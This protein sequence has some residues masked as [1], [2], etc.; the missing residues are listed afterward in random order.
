[1]VDAMFTFAN[2]PTLPSSTPL[3]FYQAIEADYAGIPLGGDW[4]GTHFSDYNG[5][6]YWRVQSMIR[7]E[8]GV[9]LNDSYGAREK[10]TD[11][12]Y[13]FIPVNYEFLSDNATNAP[14]M[15]HDYRKL[16]RENCL[17]NFKTLIKAISKTPAMLIYLSGQ[18][19]TKTVP[20]ENFARE[21]FE[22]FT[23]GKENDEANQ[24]YTED[25]IKAA[26]KIFSGWRI[27]NFLAP[28]PWQINFDYNYHNRDNKQ[29]SSFF[30]NQI[31]N[32]QVNAAGA[33]EYDIFFDM[34]F[35]KQGLTIAKYICR[36]MYRYFVY[37]EIDANTE[38]NIIT[39]L[40]NKLVANNW[41]TKSVFEELF[42]SEHF[43]DS[44]N[45][46]V[47]IKSPI[48]FHLGLMRSLNMSNVSPAGFTDYVNQ[49]NIWGD[50]QWNTDK[51]LEQGIGLVPNVS[52]WKAYYQSPS[53]YQNWINS[54]TI[55][56]RESMI[57]SYINGYTRHTL[58]L[59]I[60]TIAYVQ[61]FGSTIV[62]E[63]DLLIE[64]VVKHLLPLDIDAVYKTDTLKKA[65]LLK[66]Q[67]DPYY[68]KTAWNNYLADSTNTTKKNTVINL[69]K[70]MITGVLKLAE[71]Q[72]M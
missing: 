54:N 6:N 72:L 58:K 5:N 47:M 2:T 25:D 59:Q 49:Y 69:L 44:I 14:T 51:N 34:L 45:R 70:S 11:F 4:T 18:F 32:N 65:N 9:R 52:G 71:Y 68:W 16:L 8:W 50:F 13:H 48:D 56:Q 24:K 3:N 27:N 46:G 39:P 61:Q 22:L 26:S 53:Y 41:E 64:A 55:Q 35:A 29:F 62:P 7:W 31:I 43:F 63:A 36:K 12:W 28:Y 21:L 67:T 66:N 33:N 15:V 30:D 40:A 20:N 57:S 1:V 37:Y 23:I 42:K 17:G 19:S 10:L 60:D 38:A